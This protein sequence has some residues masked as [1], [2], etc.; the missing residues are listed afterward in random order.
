MVTPTQTPYGAWPSPLTSDFL[1]GKA[2]GLSGVAFIGPDLYWG[3]S[4]PT[5][6]GRIAIAVHRA[7]DGSTTDVTPAPFNARTRVHEY[8]GGAVIFGRDGTVYFSNFSDQKLYR[9]PPGGAPQALTS[10]A[11]MRYADG[12][13]DS[14]RNRLICVR[15]D[16]TES[17]A[18]PVN[19]LIAI[20]LDSGAE[21]ILVDGHDFF[22]APRISP[23]GTR[24]CWLS[25]D[26]PNMPWDGCTLHVATFDEAGRPADVRVVAGGQD[27]SIFQPTWSPDGMLYFVSDR[28]GWWNLHREVDGEV[29]SVALADADFGMPQWAFGQSTYAFINPER[30]VAAYA[31]QGTWHLATID[32]RT[33]QITD[34]DT[35][36]TLFTGF[37]VANGQVV[38]IAAGPRHSL[39]VVAIDLAGGAIEVIKRSWAIDL[40]EEL[41]SVPQAVEYP[42]EDGLTAHAF[43]YPPRNG[44]AV[45]PDGEKPPLLVCT[46]GGPTSSAD[47]SLSM[48][49]Q[50]WTSRGFAVL[51]VNY[52]GSSGYG[53]AYRRRLDRRWGVTDIDDCVNGVRYLV[54]QGLV[55]PDRL[56]IRGSSAGGYTTLGALAFRDVFRAGASHF[57]VGDLAALARETHKFESRYL[58]SLVGP[59]PQAED[60]YAERSPIHHVDGLNCPVIFFQG[61]DD[62]IVPPNQAVSM[63]DALRDKG[64]PV[65]HLAFEGEGHGFRRAETIKRVA[66][67]ELYF[68]GRIFGFHPAGEVQPVTIENL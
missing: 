47:A 51:D 44:H 41:I 61:L 39:A 21:T 17:G 10:S 22:A 59:Y 27:E 62:R 65:A 3:E 24:W 40:D 49:V 16:H 23:D 38:T 60:V 29:A 58:D 66:D 9:V 31:S 11:G 45:A 30:V 43:Y 50:Y 48:P 46:H 32:T 2:I 36:Y 57:G 12:V 68:Y 63:A 64:V 4:R 35:P 33:G 52:G 13:V 37:A 67:A 53:R 15:E 5:E 19:T 34:I 6:G 8:G 1:M 20:D 42:T 26:H 14:A 56:A 25:W 28:T 7:V 55:D 18:E 54:E